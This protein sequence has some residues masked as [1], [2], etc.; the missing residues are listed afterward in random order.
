MPVYVVTGKL[1]S[2][3]TLAMVGR[4]R[5]YLEKGRPVASNIDLDVRRL[6]RKAPRVPMVRLP[7]RPTVAD[8]EALGT[9]HATGREELNGAIVLDECGTWL[10]SRQWADK[11]RQALIDWF[12]HS[13][14]FGWDVF[15]IVQNIALLD[16]QLRDAIAEFCVTCRRLDRVR[17]PGFGRLISILTLGTFK[18]HMPKVHVATVRYGVGPGAVTADTWLYRG[19]DLYGAY[20]TVQVV[21]AGEVS[22]MY[23]WVW[24]VTDAERSQWRPA[25]KPKL[26]Q[27][28]AVMALPP[29]QRLSALRQCLAQQAALCPAP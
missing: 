24:Y 10:N 22:G 19:R 7:D 2:G 1:G 8:M 11:G 6:L 27:V 18:G 13:R 3:K 20:S 15:L 5:D 16:K 29:A 12:L 9:V 26:P 21:R 28:A 14:K 25:P 23:S 4:M 17:I